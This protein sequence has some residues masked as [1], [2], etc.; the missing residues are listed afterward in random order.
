M[1]RVV[2][3]II[4][5]GLSFSAYSDFLGFKSSDNVSKIPA[6][7]EKIKSLK[8]EQG[9]IFEDS[10]NQL[11]RSLETTLEE[12]KLYCSGESADSAGKVISRDQKQVCFRKLKSNYLEAIESVF[13]LKKQYL[14]TI[15]NNQLEKMNQIQS[16]IKTDIDKSF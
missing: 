7:A 10:F 1:A 9:P 15:H 14:T 5:M 4:L 2:L 6:L 8:V 3:T 16:K 13:N 12:E 11:V